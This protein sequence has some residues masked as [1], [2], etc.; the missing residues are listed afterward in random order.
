MNPTFV[1]FI[2]PKGRK[3]P[4]KIGCSNAPADRLMA[5]GAW[6][7]YPLELIGSVPGGYPEESYLHSC[8]ADHHSHREWF[9]P[10]AQ[11]LTAIQAV[12]A[13]GSVEVLRE[14]FSPSGSIRSS[15]NRRRNWSPSKKLLRSYESKVR[16]AVK[17]L[18]DKDEHGAWAEP[19]AVTAIFSKW[20]GGR[21]WNGKAFV[22][23]EPI[24][25]TAEDI[26]V[27]EDYLANPAAVSVIPSFRRPKTSICIPH[28][29]EEAA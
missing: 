21:R 18:R 2:K 20:S 10:N 25:P 23:V 29:L 6:S 19:D 22:T 13:A 14:S 17:R 3:G 9:R 4:I 7:P 8:F 1:Y 5:L 12:L 11:L 27:I 24:E 28:V 26:K 15:R 16:W